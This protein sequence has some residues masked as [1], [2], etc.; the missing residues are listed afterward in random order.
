MTNVAFDF[1]VTKIG[2]VYT[3][4]EISCFGPKIGNIVRSE[5]KDLPTIK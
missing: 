1:S 5:P 4:S 3:G 2:S